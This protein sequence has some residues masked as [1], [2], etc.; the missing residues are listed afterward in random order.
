MYLN[1]KTYNETCW[2]CNEFADSD[3]HK[4]KKS[5]ITSRYGKGDY[6]KNQQF[7]PVHIKNKETAIRGPKARILT[8]ENVFCKKC[9]NETSQPWD[10]SYSIFSDYLR[11]NNSLILKYGEID[12]KNIYG[13]EWENKIKDLFRY[14]I[15]IFGCHIATGNTEVSNDLID[16]LTEKTEILNHIKFKFYLKPDIINL[17][18]YYK[19]EFSHLNEYSHLYYGRVKWIGKSNLEI[20][21]L[22]GWFT[23]SGISI[24]WIYNL[25]IGK[26]LEFKPFEFKQT[27]ILTNLMADSLPKN[28]SKITELVE[29][30]ENYGSEKIELTNELLNE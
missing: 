17:Q 25:S 22:T 5:D 21:S 15:K 13:T 27:E 24:Y 19:K 26:D 18:K 12:F 14:F 4:F 16:F 20:E 23:N 10:D 29:Y 9:N 8:F 6:S 2:I 28:L 30:I 7:Q 3:E 1:S 11:K